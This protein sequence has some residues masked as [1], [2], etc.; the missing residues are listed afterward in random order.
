MCERPLVRLSGARIQMT[1]VY[2]HLLLALNN[3][4]AF[5]ELQEFKDCEKPQ[6]KHHK[7]RHKKRHALFHSQWKGIIT[8]HFSTIT[9]VFCDVY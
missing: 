9:D 1:A 5:Y 3:Y 8:I 6:N 7:N 4:V 2:N